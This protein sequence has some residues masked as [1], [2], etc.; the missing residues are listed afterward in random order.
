MAASNGI[1]LAE[2]IAASASTTFFIAG[3]FFFIYRFLVAR[4]HLNDKG[5][6]S[7]RREE[8]RTTR[9]DQLRQCSGNVKGLIVDE[10][11]V[12]VFYL[13]K[14]EGGQVQTHFPKVV[15]N[16]SYEDDDEEEEEKRVDTKGERAKMPKPEAVHSLNEPSDLINQGKLP[17]PFTQNPTSEALL[18]LPKL[19]QRLP[20]KSH[21]PPF[22]ITPP[23]KLEKQALESLSPLPPPPSINVSAPPPPPPPPPPPFV[24]PPPP[25]PPQLPRIVRKKSLPPTPPKLGGDVLT[26]KPPPTPKGIPKNK[27]RA[28]ASAGDDSTHSR[29]SVIGQTKMKPLHWD[30]VMAA[31]DHSMVWDQIT[32]GS[33]RFD[34]Q[35]MENLFGYNITKGQTTETNNNVSASTKSNAAPTAQVFLLDPRKSQNTAIVLK[36][37]TIS[38][39]EIINGL[40]DGHGLGSETLEKLTKISPTKEEEIKILQFN[41]NPNKLADAESFLYHILKAVPSAFSRFNAML[42]Q[43]NYDP[44]ILHLKESLQTLELGCKELRSRGFFLKL[45]EAILK[46]GNRMN[47]GTARGNAQGFNL[48]ALLKLSDVKST[49]AKTTLLH[50]VVEQVAQSEGRGL[51][52][53]QRSQTSK[54]N[55]DNLTAEEKREKYLI[56]GL[57]LLGGLSFELSNVKKAATI[58]YDSLIRISFTLTSRVDEIRK[59]LTQCCSAESETGGF[60]REMK[61]FLEECEEELKVVREEQTRVMEL[62]KRT[63]EYYQ[64]GAAK[65]KEAQP[66]QL[67]VIVRGFLDMVDLV[68]AEISRQVQRKS[69]STTT[70]GSASPPLSP[71][72]L[73]PKKLQNFHSHFN[74]H[75]SWSS[76][77]SDSEDDFRS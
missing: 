52:I 69:T 59:V 7:F 30:K 3:I 57:P 44:E 4:R 65:E 23:K 37:L 18:S 42:F 14:L 22:R 48:S 66:L 62:V 61:V 58:D 73:T 33:F 31:V 19:Q 10:N 38:R 40:L 27:S 25:L 70:V 50:F 15:F 74:S 67:F 56:Q 8:V 51:V 21:A 28:E 68:C 47:A 60:A 63:T 49:D 46:A 55:S 11:G 29:V 36:S 6:G 45:L 54:P 34:D 72:V 26:P 1:V 12:D 76:S 20:L 35:L 16:P 24:P 5:S 71:S 41:G 39:K 32:D 77:S 9:E 17:K 53:N 2:I 75:V 64:A 43:A 13:R